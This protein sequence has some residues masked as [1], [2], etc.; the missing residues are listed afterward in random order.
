MADH[1]RCTVLDLIGPHNRHQVLRI[2]GAAVAAE[3]RGQVN[4]ANRD[5]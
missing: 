4:R 3:N 5:D 2:V 1:L